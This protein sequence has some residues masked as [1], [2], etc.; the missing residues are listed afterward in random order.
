MFFIVLRSDG[1]FNERR[2]KK[3]KDK[4]N[5]AK[6][7]KNEETVHC[8]QNLPSGACLFGPK[9]LGETLGICLFGVLGSDGKF[10]E[11]RRQI[12]HKRTQ[13]EETA[14]RRANPG[15]SF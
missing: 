6:Q 3:K 10:N 12:K 9:G 5:N 14:C 8:L 15:F 13:K 11:R 2:I 4:K 7:Q 1:K